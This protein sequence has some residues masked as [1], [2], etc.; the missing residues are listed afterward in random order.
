MLTRSAC[1]VLDAWQ[2]VTDAGSDSEGDT[3]SAVAVGRRR[4]S[5]CNRGGSRRLG[6]S[7]SLSVSLAVSLL[8]LYSSMLV[9]RKRAWVV[10]H[11]QRRWML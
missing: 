10:I 6:Q 4:R 2:E 5:D 1:R 11:V 8:V 7:V 3:C 9:G